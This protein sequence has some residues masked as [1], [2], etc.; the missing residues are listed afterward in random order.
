MIYFYRKPNTSWPAI[1]HTLE[2]SLSKVLVPFYPVAGRLRSVGGG[3]FEL[4]CN[5]KGA[6]FVAAELNPELVD[7]GDFTPS[8]KFDQFLIPPID[9][10]VPIDEVPVLVAQFTKFECGGISLSIAMSHV[11]ADGKSMANFVAEWARL[12]RGELLQT[13]PVLDRKAFRAGEPPSAVPRFD[14][15]KDFGNH[16]FLLKLPSAEEVSKM[17]TTMVRLRLD[18]GQVETL[19]KMANN[20]SRGKEARNRAAATSFLIVIDSRSR[21]RQPSP[22]GYFGNAIFDIATCHA[23]D[24]MSQP[25][26][27]GARKIRGAIEKVTDDYVWSAIDFLKNESELTKFQYSY[28]SSKI[29]G[30][31]LLG[32][33]NIGLVNWVNLAFEGM[34]FGWGKEIYYGPGYHEIDGDAWLLR[35][36]DDQEGSLAVLLCLLEDH[37]EDFTKYFYEDL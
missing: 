2:S 4:D 22:T 20:Q 21:I 34:D 25:L 35:G 33:P 17:K 11:V 37:V 10:S 7:F 28:K 16:P 36:S 24:L 14:H 15:S 9:Y 6:V 12:A 19:K 31:N 29:G 18:K 23:D 13:A 26:S 27:Y 5:G 8:T 3:R 30:G 1:I 32:N